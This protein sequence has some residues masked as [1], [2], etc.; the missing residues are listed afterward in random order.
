MRLFRKGVRLAARPLHLC[1]AR[2]VHR[3]LYRDRDHFRFR[4]DLGKLLRTLQRGQHGRLGTGVHRFARRAL[5]FR[6]RH[7][8]IRPH[9]RHARRAGRKYGDGGHAAYPHGLGGY[10]DLLSHL[11][12]R[13]ALHLFGEDGG[14][15]RGLL[16]RA[17]RVLH[18]ERALRLIS[19]LGDAFCHGN[20]PYH[21][22]GRKGERRL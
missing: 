5:A 14:M 16:R 9:R 3:A 4:R 13:R 6:I 7:L 18:A 12:L 21:A 11:H 1:D 20:A 15:L 22:F 2:G 10:S 8:D 19:Q 17:S